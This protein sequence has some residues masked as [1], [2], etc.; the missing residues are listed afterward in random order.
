[1]TQPTA[2]A[3]RP[4]RPLQNHLSLVNR[5]RCATRAQG[6]QARRRA[7]H[8]TH[9][10]RGRAGV[11]RG[12]ALCGGGADPAVTAAGARRVRLH[13]ANSSAERARQRQRPSPLPGDDAVRAPARITRDAACCPH[14]AN[15]RYRI[16]ADQFSTPRPAISAAEILHHLPPVFS[17]AIILY[18]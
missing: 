3:P 4:P 13:S 11:P 5:R 16:G 6:E 14:S 9:T 17:Y 8:I 2:S 7:W 12:G 15:L 18:S 10:R 1:M